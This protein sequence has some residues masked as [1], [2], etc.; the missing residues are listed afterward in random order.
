MSFKSI[1]WKGLKWM[2]NLY[3][4][5]SLLLFLALISI[6]GT[7]IEQDQSLNYYKQHYPIDKP[8]L[9]FITWKK[10]IFLGLNHLYS[11][12]WFLLILL[13]FFCSL[14]MCTFSTQLPVLKYSK[15]WIFLYNHESLDKKPMN[16]S[17]NSSSFINF[18]YILNIQN[19]FIFHKGQ[20]VYAYKGLLGKVA[21]I[22]VH[23]SIIISFIGFILRMTSGW[24]VQEIVPS[25]EIFHLQNIITSGYLS[26]VPSRLVGKVNDF[27]ITLNDDQSIKQFF[28]N[29]SLLNSQ[30]RV[31]FRSY[32]SVNHPLKFQGMTIYQTDW[33]IN[34][35]RLSIGSNQ[36]IV[37]RLNKIQANNQVNNSVWSCDL[38]FHNGKQISIIISNLRNTISI[39]DA[40]GFLITT[41]EYGQWNIIYG[42]PI[43]FKDLLV[44]TGLQ[45]KTDPGLVISYMGFSVLIVSIFISYI[46]YSQIWANHNKRILKFSGQTSRALIFYE[47]EMSQIYKQCNYLS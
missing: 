12:Y 8:V 36:E 35:L 1:L 33:Q 43:L 27:F 41:T 22:F 20:G 6:L 9:Y 18:I 14:I 13:L 40:K 26:I 19:Y 4:S 47:N 42:V 30:G 17:M 46:S 7:L 37:R 34:A 21:P 44:S 10:I 38:V 5:I 2:S 29:I 32:I 16:Y 24:V 25:G 28:S 11:T 15:Q 31:L 39:Y 23:F 45:V 3:F